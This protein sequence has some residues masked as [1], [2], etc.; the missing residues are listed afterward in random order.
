MQPQPAQQLYYSCGPNT[1]LESWM[2]RLQAG[3][4]VIPVLTVQAAGNCCED[5]C[6]T[7]STVSKILL[8]MSKYYGKQVG[9]NKKH[10]FN[11]TKSEVFLSSPDTMAELFLPHSG[12]NILPN[13]QNPVFNEY[14]SKNIQKHYSQKV[15][16]C[17][18]SQ[19]ASWASPE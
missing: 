11:T 4:A 6:P 16:I 18:A 17:V 2:S 13:L 8:P 19:L 1:R 5:K 10:S 12:K 15:E 14:C 9:N 3:L 7:V